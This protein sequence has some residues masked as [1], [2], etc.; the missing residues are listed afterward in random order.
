MVCRMRNEA[1]NLLLYEY[2]KCA[3]TIGSECDMLLHKCQLFLGVHMDK[4]VKV[5]MKRCLSGVGDAVRHQSRSVRGCI[6]AVPLSPTI[7]QVSKG[8]ILSLAMYSNCQCSWW[9][10]DLGGEI[11]EGRSGDS[12]CSW[13][14]GDL[15]IANVHGEGEIW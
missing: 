10:G 13:W 11:L 14:R 6:A 3:E 5:Q 12:Q 1:E 4:W 2:N 9:S 8:Q 7:R 15:V